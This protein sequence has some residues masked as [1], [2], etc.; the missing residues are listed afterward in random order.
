MSKLLECHLIQKYPHLRHSLAKMPTTK[1]PSLS[2]AA[3][4]V[5]LK[6]TK[7]LCLLPTA[8]PVT[9]KPTKASSSHPSS[10]PSSSVP[11][12]M[13]SSSSLTFAPP[14]GPFTSYDASLCSSICEI[15]FG[16]SSIDPSAFQN[17][18]VQSVTIPGS[19]TSIGDDA[20]YGVSALNYLILSEGLITIGSG[21]FLQ[22]S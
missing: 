7:A 14:S 20:F 15:P 2:P 13:L 17:T 8:K 11:S 1:A 10:M 18:L 5:T 9:P 12:S 6:A 3:K 16:Y 19:C 4:P 21:A 22:T